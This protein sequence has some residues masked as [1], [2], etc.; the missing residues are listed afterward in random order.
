MTKGKS[1]L[2]GESMRLSVRQRFIDLEL[3]DRTK[4]GRMARRTARARKE[5][6]DRRDGHELVD[7][8]YS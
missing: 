1:E 8:H 6:G 4:M 7:L 2:G 3:G 5:P